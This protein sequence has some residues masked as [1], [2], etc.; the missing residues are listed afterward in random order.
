MAFADFVRERVPRYQPPAISK[1]STPWS[2]HKLKPGDACWW[3]W[4]GKRK[5]RV[6]SVDISSELVFGDWLLG[7]DWHYNGAFHFSEIEEYKE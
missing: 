3:V 5:V 2:P 4:S 1:K 7:N 6:K